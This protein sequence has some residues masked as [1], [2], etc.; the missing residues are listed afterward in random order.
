[1]RFSGPGDAIAAGIGMVH[2]HFMLVPVFTVT[3]NIMLGVERRTGRS[4]ALDRRGCASVEIVEL[5]ERTG[6]SVDPDAVRR[7]AAGRRAA[8]RRDPE[9]AVPRRPRSSI[10]DEPTAVLTPQETE[11]LFDVMRSLVKARASP[12]IFITH[13]LKEVLEIADRITVLRRG[14]VVGTTHAGRDARGGAG[15]DDGRPRRR[16]RRGQGARR[17]PGEPVLELRDLVVRDDR[18]SPR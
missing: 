6:C 9:D 18:G 3:E 8:A 7:G 10:L 2:Q 16:A 1:M 4:A 13:K 14:R 5:S 11:E 12:I 15:G 17:E